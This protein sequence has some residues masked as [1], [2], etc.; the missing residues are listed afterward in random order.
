MLTAH[1]VLI[2]DHQVFNKIQ[3]G[4]P[5]SLNLNAIYQESQLRW[6]I[7]IAFGGFASTCLNNYVI[8]L[9]HLGANKDY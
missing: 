7:G 2:S 3:D 6:L 5:G 9:P 4:K 1:V 8:F